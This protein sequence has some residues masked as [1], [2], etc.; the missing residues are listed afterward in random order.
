MRTSGLYQDKTEPK[1][2][3]LCHF[4]FLR[5][6]QGNIIITDKKSR[7]TGFSSARMYI[8]KRT[9]YSINEKLLQVNSERKRR[10]FVDNYSIKTI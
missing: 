8:G 10:N 5:F 4:Y 2:C 9:V 1:L 7:S 6:S 3:G